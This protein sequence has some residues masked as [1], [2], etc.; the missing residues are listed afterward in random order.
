MIERFCNYFTRFMFWLVSMI[1]GLAI[2]VSLVD[3]A[4]DVIGV[5]GVFIA[6]AVSFICARNNNG[7]ITAEYNGQGK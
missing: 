4:S 7:F 5:S 2:I 3:W 1:V 6:T